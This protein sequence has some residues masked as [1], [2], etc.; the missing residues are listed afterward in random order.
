MTA[1]AAQERRVLELKEE[2]SKAEKELE[3]LKNQWATHEST[4]RRNESRRMHHM[5]PMS[6]SSAKNVD[7]G[8]DPDGSSAWMYEEMEKRKALLG[9]NSKPSHRRV[10]S[11][12]RHTK[13]LSLLSPIKTQSN[14]VVHV[15]ADEIDE[16]RAR[17]PVKKVI[18]PVQSILTLDSTSLVGGPVLNLDQRGRN[19]SR[20]PQREDLLRTGK[21]VATDLRDGLWTFFEDLR[22]AAV[23]DEPRAG[24]NSSTMRAPNSARPT[25]Q[26]ISP[27]RANGKSVTQDTEHGSEAANSFWKDHGLAEPKIL[28]TSAATKPAKVRTPQK[29]VLNTF[30]SDGDSWEAWDSPTSPARS[31]KKG[32]SS[33]VSANSSPNTSVASSSNIGSQQQRPEQKKEAI[34]WPT[35]TNL[36][37]GQLRRTATH[38]MEELERS[39]TPPYSSDGLVVDRNGGGIGGFVGSTHDGLLH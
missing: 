6:I 29:P 24:H 36:A 18:P 8:D 32:N 4:K 22:Q 31:A 16:R 26:R 19:R 1:L 21:Q 23:G 20:S 39:L 30:D 33:V 2:L 34:P 27:S 37:P 38:L 13:E 7:L 15:I 35:L 17:D 10:F 25:P 5:R 28:S 12:S 11:G 14:D 9:N 3:G